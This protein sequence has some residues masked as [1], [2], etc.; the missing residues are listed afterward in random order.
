MNWAILLHKYITFWTNLF[1]Y[2]Q[3][4]RTVNTE[5]NRVYVRRAKGGVV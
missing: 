1:W 3:I 5:G 2:I 4:L